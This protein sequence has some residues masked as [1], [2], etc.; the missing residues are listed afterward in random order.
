MQLHPER[1]AT[2]RQEA[3][4]L[5]QIKKREEENA[6]DQD[7]SAG[8]CRRTQGV[9]MVAN[10]ADGEQQDD[11][12]KQSGNR[13][14]LHPW[15]DPFEARYLWV[16]LSRN[17]SALRHPSRARNNNWNPGFEPMSVT[18]LDLSRVG[19]ATIAR[20]RRKLFLSESDFH[21]G[22]IWMRALPHHDAVSTF[23]GSH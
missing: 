16:T 13:R 6:T 17:V 4:F 11:C 7:V 8:K 18:R 9:G 1:G 22:E 21:V 5:S 12:N 20:D 2:K 3:E 10:Q 15:L 14:S 23:D 19:Q